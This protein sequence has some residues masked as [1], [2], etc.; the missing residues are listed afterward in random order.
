MSVYGSY[1]P[2]Q[3]KYVKVASPSYKSPKAKPIKEKPVDEF[4]ALFNSYVPKTGCKLSFNWS[5]QK[6]RRKARKTTQ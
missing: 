3:D 2:S 1:H 6:V 5:K 4:T